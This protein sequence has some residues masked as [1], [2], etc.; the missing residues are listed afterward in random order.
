MVQ[1]FPDSFFRIINA[2]TGLCLAARSGGVSYGSQTEHDTWTGE[3]K[4][5]AFSHTKDQVLGVV[6]PMGDRG[7][8]WFIDNR[9]N[10]RGEEFWH[11]TNLNKDI[12]SWFN[13]HASSRDFGE[14]T[15]P[16]SLHGAGRT[17]QNQW[18][19]RKRE[20]TQFYDFLPVPQGDGKR[21]VGLEPTGNGDYR[22]VLDDEGAPH[23]LWRF[24][25]VTVPGET[26]PR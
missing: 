16:L 24:E 3:G 7:E 10:S 6:K 9:K 21:L 12:R 2:D 23:Q 8:I 11:L 13:L 1:G 17:D 5:V 14:P 20:G 26:V 19:A 4:E 15:L 25:E 22:A 18:E